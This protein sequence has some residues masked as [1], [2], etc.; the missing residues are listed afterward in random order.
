M[1][2]MK[3]FFLSSLFLLLVGLV[4]HG[5]PGGGGGLNISYL[6]Y[7][8][9]D[10]LA[11]N[12]KNLK[13]NHYVMN[14]KFN[15]VEYQ[16]REIQTSKQQYYTGSREWFYLPP[17]YDLRKDQV[18]PNQR[19]EIIY[20]VDTMIVDFYGIMQENGIGRTE[21]LDCIDFFPGKYKFHLTESERFDSC[22]QLREQFP[23]QIEKLQKDMHAGI[24]QQTKSNL[25]AWHI[26]Q[27]AFNPET[28]NLWLRYNREM[29]EEFGQGTFA[30]SFTRLCEG[31]IELTSTHFYLTTK[32]VPTHHVD[33]NV[34]CFYF[35]HV[36]KEYRM[37]V[38]SPNEPLK[39][40]MNPPAEENRIAQNYA[41]ALE[42]YTVYINGERF[43]GQILLRISHEYIYPQIHGS[44]VEEIHFNYKD[45]KL[46]YKYFSVPESALVPGFDE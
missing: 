31:M 44:N 3:P 11:F 21:Q 4:A 36:F 26:L 34:Y 9:G 29:C 13:I 46:I 43:T 5:Q 37:L 38:Q 7:V 40:R 6:R 30:G 16:F 25:K 14:K 32:Q 39:E 24:T 20:K 23:D 45:G 22:W 33:T 10:T 28:N 1:L 35:Y 27:E 15:K 2:A 41:D 12:D 17:N 19:L 8:N 18:C 42:K